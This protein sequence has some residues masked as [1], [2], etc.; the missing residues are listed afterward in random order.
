MIRKSSW[1][2]PDPSLYN[3]SPFNGLRCCLSDN[4]GLSLCPGPLKTLPNLVC[5]LWLPSLCDLRLFC[6][7]PDSFTK[8]PA[9]VPFSY[10]V[11]NAS[12]GILGCFCHTKARLSSC[13]RNHL[14]HRCLKF[15][16][17]GPSQEK[18]VNPCDRKFMLMWQPSLW[19]KILWLSRSQV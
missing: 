16:L 10:N 12:S 15:L 7:G 3:R 8:L 6:K 2:D 5:H 14:V 18:F 19:I 11:I 13:D 9:L 1:L 4:E 17:F